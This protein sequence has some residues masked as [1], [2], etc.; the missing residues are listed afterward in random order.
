MAPFMNGNLS[1]YIVPPNTGVPELDVLLVGDS[2]EEAS[3]LGRKG[4][5]DVAATLVAPAIAKAVYHAI[6]KG[7]RDL[8]ITVEKLL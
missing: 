5:G 6:G 3:L 1:G 8:P 7:V 2:D 4:L